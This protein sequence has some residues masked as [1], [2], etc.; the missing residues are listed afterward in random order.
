M[1]NNINPDALWLFAGILWLAVCALSG[2]GAMVWDWLDDR[3]E[4]MPSTK[5]PITSLLMRIFSNID[6]GD[7]RFMQTIV[8]VIALMAAFLLVKI[9]IN[10]PWLLPI[11]ATVVGVLYTA[12][13]ARRIH[14]KLNAHLNGHK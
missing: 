8:V 1:D 10:V 4:G 2:L 11:I 7:A 6:S 13:F 14:K 9:Q 5:G 12:R 3:P